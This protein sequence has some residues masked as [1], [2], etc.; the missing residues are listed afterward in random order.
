MRVSIFGENLGDIYD[1]N[2]LFKHFNELKDTRDN[3][4]KAHILNDIIFITICAVICGAD[5]FY[6]IEDFAHSHLEW[7]RKY[8][9]LKNGVPSHDTYGH[10]EKLIL[11]SL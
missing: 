10:L 1:Y 5:S 9:K 7:L 3:R 8:I 11:F 2:R 6:A 4:G